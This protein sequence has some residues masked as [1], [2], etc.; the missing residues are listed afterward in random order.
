MSSTTG[1]RAVV[2]HKRRGTL[3]RRMW[4]RR[5]GRPDGWHVTSRGSLP[6]GAFRP[7]ARPLPDSSR[8]GAW[9]TS[10]LLKPMAKAGCRRADLWVYA[11]QHRVSRYRAVIVERD[12]GAAS[13]ASGD[14]HTN[15]SRVAVTTA[16]TR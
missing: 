15:Q 14:G 12:T 10:A 8:S 11:T 9:L 7:L 16:A 2:V 5:P 13:V 6:K 1:R 3:S 4:G